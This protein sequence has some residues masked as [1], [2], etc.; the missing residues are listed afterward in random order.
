VADY[1]A[2]M[3]RS[4]LLALLAAC[5][6]LAA[7]S[8]APEGRAPH[9]IHIAGSRAGFPFTTLV[10]ERL[11]REDTAAIAPLVRAG[12]SADDDIA[13]F[14]DGKGEPHPD[15]LLAS[16]DMTAAELRRCAANGIATVTRIPIG[17][18]PAGTPLL[19]IAKADE[20]A[21]TP[22]LPRLIG[23]IADALAPGGAFEQHGLVPLP[24]KARAAA[25]SRLRSLAKR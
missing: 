6:S 18:A 22:A 7:C 20:V 9:Q 13:R 25:I 8:K 15:L 3:R 17:A 4:A 16:R 23:D 5:S 14:C 11:M 1:N 10:A 24:D 19:L 21:T 12:G 2:S